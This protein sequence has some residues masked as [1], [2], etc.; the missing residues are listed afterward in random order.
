MLDILAQK[1]EE[2]DATKLNYE[3][4][5]SSQAVVFEED[6]GICK[7]VSTKEDSSVHQILFLFRLEYNGE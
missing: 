7:K 4:L 5:F 1:S 3:V 2:N 6:N